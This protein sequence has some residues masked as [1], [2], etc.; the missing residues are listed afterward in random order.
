MREYGNDSI[1]QLKGA[2]RLRL[3]PE[4]LLGSKGIDGAKH[5]VHEIVGNATDE[6]LAGFGDK[7]EIGYH[8][9]G[10]ISVRDYG[11]GV[12]LGWNEK[13]QNWNYFL[14]FE[15]LY[16]GGKYS[17]NMDVLRQ[18]DANGWKNFR[19][20]DYPYLVTIGLNGLGAAST[21]YTSEF[22][23]VI[24]YRNGTAS[25]MDFKK[26]VHVLEELK[27]YPTNEP[28]GTYIHWKPDREVFTDVNIPAKWFE[29]LCKSLSYISG[30]NVEF[31]N[32]GTVTNY[33][34]S[35]IGQEMTEAVKEAITVHSFKHIVDGEGDICICDAEVSIG[36]QGRGS[37]YFHN[38]VQVSG[39]AHSSGYYVA[40]SA[41]FG[42]ISNKVGIKIRES[43]YSGK[44]SCI[45]ST[46]ANKSSL[47][48]Q[49]KDSI[50]DGWI[51][52]FLSNVINNTLRSEY[53][54]GTPW[55]ERIVNEVIEVAKNRIAVAAMAST[56][57]DVQK[58]TARHKVSQK[59]STC[60]SYESG[61][62]GET[63][64][65]IVE[66]DSAGGQVNNSRDSKFQCVF[67]VRGKSLNVFK[68]TIPQLIANKE[69]RDIIS[70]LG[71][72]VDLG[73]DD[74]ETFNINKLKVGK[75]IFC[76]DADID[77]KHINMLLTLIFI[78]LF[79]ELLHRGHVYIAESPLY[80]INKRDGSSDYCMDNA[81]L[82][83]KRAEIGEHNI[84]S[85]DRFKGLGEVDKEILW[86]STLNPATRRLRQLKVDRGDS[87]MYETLEVLFGKSTHRRK[88]AIL[89]S[90]LGVDYDEALAQM[91]SISDYIAGLGMDGD[92]EYIDVEV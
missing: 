88:K 75:I 38:R 43:D 83:K 58:A 80:I 23:T 6:R 82:A 47:R 60:R 27:V 18:I 44:F 85:I 31:N 11:R 57:K 13:E 70:I 53:E 5:T 91:D 7:L 73:I 41:F 33:P 84:A 61:K 86:D 81:E 65:L 62:A 29:A 35:S 79:P 21:Q 77:G 54:K 71:C 26:G 45:I 42:Y 2:D 17:K 90:M 74:F 76:A 32:Q 87:D 68:A 30:F 51:A 89:G 50:D 48:N 66:G 56:V 12:P 92:I 20:Q 19:L 22:F 34:A 64:L 1:S 36:A 4:A 24:S 49:T 10:S 16:A 28:N 69:I 15:E 40:M 14:I 59:F 52:D 37:E 55:V 46:L 72:G 78:R 8:E 9:D 3:R 67:P 39:G 25:Q 63:E